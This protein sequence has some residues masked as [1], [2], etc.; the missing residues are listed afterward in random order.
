M[1]RAL[2]TFALPVV[3]VALF[4]STA[5]ARGYYL[6]RETA[7]SSSASG[8]V[9][10]RGTITSTRTAGPYGPVSG[11]SVGPGYI[12][13]YDGYAPAYAPGYGP[14]YYGA[15]G[16]PGYSPGAYLPGYYG[17]TGYPPGYPY[18][19]GYGYPGYGTYTTCTGAVACGV[20][21]SS[22]STTY[23]VGGPGVVGPGATVI[24]VTPGP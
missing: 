5:C 7:W 8:F 2:G 18:P 19:P 20:S 16:A 12:T 6:R 3:L 21:G 10:G 23:G 15:G 9:A 11:V 1:V 22:T 4:L 24:V 14:P 17:S 13:T